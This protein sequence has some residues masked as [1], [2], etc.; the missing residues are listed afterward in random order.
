[1]AAVNVRRI[2]GNCYG[3]AQKTKRKA[4]TLAIAT[5]DGMRLPMAD[6]PQ[7]RDAAAV[8]SMPDHRPKLRKLVVE[9]R[10]TI[11]ARTDSSAWVGFGKALEDFGKHKKWVSEFCELEQMDCRDCEERKPKNSRVEHEAAYTVTKLYRN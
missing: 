6:T 7:L 2:K 11:Y 5:S 9:A 3:V 4:G 1:M 8:Q 10:A